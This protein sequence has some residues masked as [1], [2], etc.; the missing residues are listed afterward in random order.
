MPSKKSS[1]LSEAEEI[2]KG[3]RRSSY[4]PVDQSFKEIAAIW[5]VVLKKEVT[6]QDVAKCMIGLKL[7]RESNKHEKDN[8]IDICGYTALL[9]EIS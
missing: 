5:S 8:L 2:I 6:P 4:G 3:P 9:Q 1:I 7:Q